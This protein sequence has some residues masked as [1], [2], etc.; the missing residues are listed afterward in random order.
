MLF[1]LFDGNLCVSVYKGL[2]DGMIRH[3]VCIL[4]GKLGRLYRFFLILHLSVHTANM[5]CQQ[6]VFV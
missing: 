4:Y 1:K 3:I 2:S 5:R 6:T